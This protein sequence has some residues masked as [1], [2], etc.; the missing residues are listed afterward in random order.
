MAAS[1]QQLSELQD[2]AWTAV[3][4][5]GLERGLKGSQAQHQAVQD[6]YAAM[7]RP[8]AA[9]LDQEM[10]RVQLADRARLEREHQQ[11]QQQAAALAQT[12]EQRNQERQALR[13]QLA[14]QQTTA[15]TW[16]AKYEALVDP[17]R[18][19]P[20]EEVA[21]ALCLEFVQP[22][23]R[24]ERHQIRINGTQFYDWHESQRRGGG[25]AIDLVMHVNQSDFKSAV[26]WL[27]DRF[28]ETAVQMAIRE[29]AEA[30]VQSEKSS[31][32]R[33]SCVRATMADRAG[34]FGVAAATGKV[35]GPASCA[36][37]AVC[38]SG[39]GDDLHTAGF[40]DARNNRSVSA[41]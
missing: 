24:H 28:G 18:S 27:A 17:V 32:C 14:V 25:G 26:A 2:R 20:L 5:L 13:Q 29:S 16:K 22:S 12:L 23:W 38:R 3:A 39:W 15:A 33:A 11:L 37:V 31:L 34:R 40:A 21:A 30:I 7:Q 6:W 10:V 8:L 41:A 19:L 1:V 4:H 36:G 9:D 35:A